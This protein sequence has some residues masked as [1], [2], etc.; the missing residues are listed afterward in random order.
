MLFGEA[1]W[2]AE[3]G[4]ASN[5]NY[6]NLVQACGLEK[7][8]AAG[9]V[10]VHAL[11]GVDLSISRGEMVAVMGPSGCGKTTLLNALSGLDEFDGGEVTIAGKSISEM[12][13]RDRTRFRAEKMGFVFQT[14][15]LIPVLSGVENVELPLLVAGTRPKEARE[16]AF[17]ALRMAGVSDQAS[18][19]PAE[20]SG[21]QQQ[22]ITV[23]RS[24]VNDPAI[25]WADEPTGA[26]DSETSKE[27][28]DLLVRLN[29]EEGQTFVLVTHDILVARRAHRLVQM[30]D[31]RIES[32]GMTKEGGHNG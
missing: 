21:G 20:M 13:D 10:R 22:R 6:D 16:K 23:A 8:Y 3:S 32:D 9:G 1:K 27:I 4:S 5:V 26:L 17:S 18:K 19:R 24:L 11:A 14:Y 7:T 2:E 29:R 12:S 25:V 31:G 30:R 28:M 15:N